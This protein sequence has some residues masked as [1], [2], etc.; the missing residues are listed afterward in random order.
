[1]IS[2]MHMVTGEEFIDL[3]NIPNVDKEL[4]QEFAHQ[5]QSMTAMEVRMVQL[6]S[7]TLA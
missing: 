2:T 4:S 7:V 6:S 1:M 5:A 3:V